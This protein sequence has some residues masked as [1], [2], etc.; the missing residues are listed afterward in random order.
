M[1]LVTVFADA[2]DPRRVVTGLIAM[3]RIGVWHAD[4]FADS[5]DQ[6]DVGTLVTID[7]DNGAQQLVGT[8][9]RALL[10]KGLQ[11]IR[12]VGGAA[13]M[14]SAATAKF[15]AAG[16]TTSDVLKDL[17]TDAGETLAD[18]NDAATSI[19]GWTSIGG[20]T[21]GRQLAELLRP[22]DGAAWRIKADGTLWVGT[23][24]WPA[25]AVPDDEWATLD[26]DHWNG[27][28]HLG[29]LAPTL[30][31]GTVLGQEKIDRVEHRI[32]GEKVRTSAWVLRDGP[33]GVVDQDFQA[34]ARG[35]S[36]PFDFYALYSGT[37]KAQDGQ[38][39][40]VQPD[41]DR[42]PTLTGLPIKNGLPSFESTVATGAKMLVG[43]S[44][45]D[46]RLPF[47]ALWGGN[48]TTSAMTIKV[49]TLTIVADSIKLG[50]EDLDQ[51]P[52]NTPV[53]LGKYIDPFT[54]ATAFAL[55]GCSGTV[56]GKL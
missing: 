42:I 37:M 47:C 11:Q 19:P 31:A 28:I 49:G 38:K 30:I 39:F 55:G 1:S 15:Y 56:L 48:E 54:G 9:T 7:M 43:W 18:D 20:A 33:G 23:E 45:G 34:V 17:A 41:D 32:N 16:A 5:D 3:P 36:R 25:S 12:I 44:G 46:P 35:S 8:V 29:M 53:V 40:D 2:G 10:Y 27:V 14:Q 50:A 24:S 52:T 26:Y 13:G 21:V 4:L 51:D 6:F 22:I